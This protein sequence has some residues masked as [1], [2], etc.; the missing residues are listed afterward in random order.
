MILLDVV[1]LRTSE[2]NPVLLFLLS[3]NSMENCP[4]LALAVVHR[5]W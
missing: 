2:C 4:S 5:S 3:V 1:G